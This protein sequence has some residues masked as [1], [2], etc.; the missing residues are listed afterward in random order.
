MASE[1]SFDVVSQFDLQEL[2]NAVDQVKREIINRYDLKGSGTEL[3]LNDNDI[4]VIAPDTM[5]LNAVKDVLFQKLV[6]RGLSPKILDIA[7]HEPSAGG[8][9]RQVMKLIKVLS[10]DN[11]KAI[12]KHIKENFPK[13]KSSIQG[14]C[15][16][17]SSKNKDDLQAV[18]ASLREKKDL[19]VPL[20]FTNYR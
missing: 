6:N 15:V 20:H 11:C 9:L 1:F 12:S 14:E 3:T 7:E 5:K 16:R 13:V 4:T 8:K 17:V 10:S 19:N 18:M 2:K